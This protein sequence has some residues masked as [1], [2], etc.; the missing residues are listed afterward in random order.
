M[1]AGVTI[2]GLLLRT[3]G[4]GVGV[5][6]IIVDP[7]ANSDVDEMLDPVEGDNEVVETVSLLG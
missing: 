1:V 6:D 4:V 7:M 3:N 5:V 2:A